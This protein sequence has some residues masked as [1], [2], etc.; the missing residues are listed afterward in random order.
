[1][2]DSQVEV[3]LLIEIVLFDEWQKEGTP[4]PAGPL[5]QLRP[6]SGIVIPDRKSA[7]CVM[8]VLHRQ[9]DLS[10]VALATEQVGGFADLLDRWQEQ[11]DQDS[12]DG[13]YDEQF[14]QG[15]CVRGAWP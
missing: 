15:E 7:Q 10:K 11:A 9:A 2:T 4:T 5:I 1:M 12:D 8:V 3:D 14:D 13:N 6:R